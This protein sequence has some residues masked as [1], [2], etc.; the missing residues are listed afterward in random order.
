V[1]VGDSLRRD[2]EGAR[3]TGMRFIWLMPQPF[4]AAHASEASNLPI[5][6]AIAKLGDL[7]R[8]LQ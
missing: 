2:G 8:I 5:E 1:L 3:R 6:H 4:G 7:M